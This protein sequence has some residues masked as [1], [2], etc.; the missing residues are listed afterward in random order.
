MEGGVRECVTSIILQSRIRNGILKF[1]DWLLQ[2]IRKLESRSYA[3]F[4]TQEAK[5]AKNK[6]LYYEALVAAGELKKEGKGKNTCY[7]RLN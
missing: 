5:I 3:P 1:W 6:D 7:F 4:E 2:S